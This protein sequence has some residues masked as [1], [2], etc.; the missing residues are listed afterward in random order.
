VVPLLG[1][2]TSKADSRIPGERESAM[3]SWNQAYNRLKDAPEFAGSA[4]Y[5]GRLLPPS[6]FRF[7][8]YSQRFEGVAGSPAG[9]T[10][11]PPSGPLLQP[12][13]S[14]AVIL[15]ITAAAYEDQQ[16]E[17]AGVLAVSPSY[18]AGRRDLF[19]ISFQYTNDEQITPNGLTMAEP[20]LGSGY[21]TIFP[22]KELL[23]PPS[24]GILCA[25]ASLVPSTLPDLSINVVYHCM[26][27]RNTN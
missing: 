15:G 27:P 3:I 26:V 6:A 18:S 22:A 2:F 16:L 14:G 1:S 24:Q 7:L 13:P 11:G 19:G 10:F 25:V 9:G 20:L 12:F 23:I 8:A 17:N 21:D 5:F 4:G